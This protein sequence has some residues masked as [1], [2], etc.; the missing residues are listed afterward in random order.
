MKVGFAARWN[1]LDKKSWSGT[2]YYSYQEIKKHHEV[3]SFH[4]QWSW[5]TREWLTM[6]KSLNKKLYGKHTVVEFLRSYAKYFSRQL[7]HDLR[8]KKIDLLF[9]SAS[10]QLIA[11][12][13]STVPVIFMIDATFKQL[14]G[15]YPYFSD[16]SN[17]NLKQGI[18]LDRK[19]FERADHCMLTSDWAKQSAVA[20]YGI[21]VNKIS[22]VPVGAN[23][24]H[25]PPFNE[26]E[27]AAPSCR[28]L[29]LGVEWERK[30]GP[31]ALETFRILQGRGLNPTL[32]IIGCVPPEDLSGEKNITVIPFLDK[33]NPTELQKLQ[34]VIAGTDMLLLPTRAECA[35]VVFSE[36]SAYGIPSISTDTG[37]VR[38]V[39]KEAVN[40]YLLLPGAQ[41]SAYAEKIESLYRQ[42][43][44][45]HSLKQT[46]RKYFE[47]TL[48]WEHW[49]QA[50]CQ[51]ADKLTG[52]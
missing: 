48:N 2:S 12:M 13:K 3:E 20:D 15:Y 44:L 25:I 35:G 26:N 5:F 31:I 32:H 45:L 40:G 1:P 46:S 51:I 19:A 11:Y 23:L 7:D 33:N 47:S 29:F 14:N 22:V 34:S 16:I 4:Y 8:K 41:A 42:P 30:G 17:Y 36:A 24:D 9:V 43:A 52:H 6:Q 10:P 50:F 21:D 27:Q 18:E 38:S 28:L 49:G 39:I 37:G